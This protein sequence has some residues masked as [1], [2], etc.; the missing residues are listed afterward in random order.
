MINFENLKKNEK[1]VYLNEL[2]KEISAKDA[3][4]IEQHQMP[5]E[6]VIKK[7]AFEPLQRNIIGLALP[8]D[9]LKSALY[10]D[11]NGS[12]DKDSKDANEFPVKILSIAYNSVFK[13][14]L[15]PGDYIHIIAGA[16]FIIN[17]VYV[18]EVKD[19][20]VMAKFIQ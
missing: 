20:Q 11:S 15:K 16:E 19:H 8:A 3:A 6:D 17:G 5:L 4:I 18:V 7:T 12:I 10:I 2:G 14:I 9:N 13:D 1:G